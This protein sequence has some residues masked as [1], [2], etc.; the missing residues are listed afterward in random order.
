[1]ENKT[2]EIKLGLYKHYKGELY[3]VVGV[4][5]HS[6]SLEELVIYKGLYDSEEF[7]KNPLWVRPKSM[8]LEEVIVDNKKILRFEFVK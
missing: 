1:M 5:R 6:E 2:N 7:G 4:A 3:E 8:F